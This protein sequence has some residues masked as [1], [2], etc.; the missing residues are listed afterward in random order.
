[1]QIYLSTLTE[2]DYDTS[3]DSIENNYDQNPEMS[4]KDRARVKHLRKSENYNYELEVIA[5]ND[6]NDV[7]GHVMLAE[8]SLFSQSREEVA[9]AISALSV[10]ATVRNQGLGKALLNAV[11]ERAN[12][13]GY[14]AIF[15]NCHSEYFKQVGY[16]EA[17]QFHISME[18]VSVENPLLVKFLKP[19]SN[20]WSSMVVHYPEVF[21]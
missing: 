17:K 8:V 4:W 13:Q 6:S 9:L 21:Y 19:Y 1:M 20:E 7:V 14:K 15:V 12:N 2:V 16:E 18:N 11:E 5:K 10:D 3:L